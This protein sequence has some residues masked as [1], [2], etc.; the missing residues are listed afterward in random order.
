MHRNKYRLVDSA[1]TCM[2]KIRL[3]HLF[4]GFE[5]KKCHLT[6][7]PAGIIYTA[8]LQQFAEF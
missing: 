6:P 4:G 5:R 8:L 2:S 7:I 1:N 3:N